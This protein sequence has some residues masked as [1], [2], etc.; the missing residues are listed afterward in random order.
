MCFSNPVQRCPPG[1]PKAVPTMRLSSS[2]MKSSM[3]VMQSEAFVE[4]RCRRMSVKTVEQALQLMCLEKKRDLRL[5][6]MLGLLLTCTCPAN[7][8]ATAVMHLDDAQVKQQ[9]PR[10][11]THWRF[12]AIPRL[13]CQLKCLRQSL[14]R[15]CVPKLLCQHLRD[16]AHVRCPS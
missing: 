3:F 9:R 5:A 11:Q 16:L 2:A 4:K 15:R 1:S 8:D 12:S 13:C 14:L 7:R 6:S 10:S